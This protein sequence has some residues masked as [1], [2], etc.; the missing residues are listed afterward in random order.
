MRK[1]FVKVT[2]KFD[3][4]GKMTPLSIEWENGTKYEIDKILDIRRAASLKVGGQGTRYLC[5]IQNR[6]TYLFYE[7]PNWFV[8]GK[9]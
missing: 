8:E 2:A 7:D 4:D 3:V 9:Q 6:E 5:K 1:V